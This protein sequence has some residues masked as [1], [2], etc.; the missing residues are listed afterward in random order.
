M[1]RIVLI[2]LRLIMN[3]DERLSIRIPSELK[4][5]LVRLAAQARR[6]LSDYVSMILEE[7]TKREEK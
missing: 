3:K 2:L 5:L 4:E 6:K 1:A 7:Y